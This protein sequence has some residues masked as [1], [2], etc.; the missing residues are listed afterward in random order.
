MGISR[1]GS[2]STKTQTMTIMYT[3]VSETAGMHPHKNACLH[4][5]PQNWYVATV[6]I[7]ASSNNHKVAFHVVVAERV[8]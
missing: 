7:F 4:A 2:E 5:C 6:F 8:Y 1:E 3:N